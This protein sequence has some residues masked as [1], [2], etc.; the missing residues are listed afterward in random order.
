MSERWVTPDDLHLQ[1]VISSMKVVYS[2]T[3]A[4]IFYLDAPA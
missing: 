2:S 4:R 1:S 3:L